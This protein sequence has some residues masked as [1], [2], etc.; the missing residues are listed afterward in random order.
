MFYKLREAAG[1][2]LVKVPRK[3]AVL[4]ELC[5]KVPWIYPPL[6]SFFYFSMLLIPAYSYL[7]GLEAYEITFIAKGGET[8]LICA[9]NFLQKKYKRVNGNDGALGEPRSCHKLGTK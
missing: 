7:Q 9:L 6:P 2:K 8:I 5:L 4:D 3:A 1:G